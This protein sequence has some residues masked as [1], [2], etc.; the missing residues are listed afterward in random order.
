MVVMKFGGTSVADQAAIERLIAHRARGAAGRRAAGR[1]RCARAGRGGVGAV[2]RDRSP[3]RRGRPGRR[4]RRRRRAHQPAGAA[5]SATSRSPRSSRD[6]SL[7]QPVVDSL[8]REF[9]EL[10]RV[11][12]ALA[13]LREVSPRWLD[14]IAATGEILSSRIV[15][16]ALTSHGLLGDLGRRAPGRGHRRRAH[17]GG[18]AVPGN[19]RGA[20]GARRSAAGGGAHSGARRL[21]RRHAASGVTTTL[22]RGGS[23][24]SAAI[25]G[26]CLGASEIQIWTDVDGML[27]AD[28][29]IVKDPQVVPHLSFAEASELAYFG[30]KVLHP[31]T[32]QPAVARNIPVRI[33]N[34]H[35]AA[36]ARHADHRR[37]AAGGSAA[38]GG[39]VEEGR[40]RGRHHLDAHADGARLPAPAVRG[41]RAVQ[42]AGRRGH[43]LRGQRVGHGR[44]SAAAAGDRRGAVGVCRGRARR[45]HGDRVRG[46]RRP[47]ATTRRWRPGAAA[48][49]GDVPMRMVSQAASRR[50][51]TFV[52]READLPTRSAAL[53]DKFFAP[54]GAC[55][56]WPECGCLL[57]SATAAWGSWSSRSRPAYGADRGRRDRRA[58][59]TSARSPTARSATSTWPSISRS[60]TR[61][62]GTCRCWRSG[63]STW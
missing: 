62:R 60:P 54:T 28:P 48:S 24:Y 49:V 34:S 59:G 53:H 63:R 50:N 61:C 15:A 47:A 46:R 17:G 10:E 3:A 4:R 58:F 45:R 26:A 9:D 16:A 25:V 57:L 39:G 23:D 29:R 32:I 11:V 13:V 14:A 42:D 2:G 27:T 22:G 20:D 21:R 35:R 43:D 41:V 55:S 36:G 40:D 1:R 37:A 18:A 33:L 52:I 38:D 31:A 19:H 56:G 5:R 30:A 12:S 6:P 44:R 7:R 8:N 51:I